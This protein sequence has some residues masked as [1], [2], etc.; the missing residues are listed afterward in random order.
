MLSQSF[1][2]LE[3]IVYD[4]AGTFEE[5]CAKFG[6]PR[7]RYHRPSEKRTTSGRFVAAASLCTGEFIGLLDDDDAY[8]PHF[9]RRI[10]ETL[11]RHP[12]AGVAFCR[13]IW[14]IDGDRHP[15]AIPARAGVQ[16]NAVA[17][18]L[19]SRWLVG[20]SIMLMRRHALEHSQALHHV[21]PDV[22]A[23]VVI[24]VRLSL[25][26]WSHVFVDEPLVVLRWHPEQ[27]SRAGLPA[28]ERTVATHR[29]LTMPTAA[30]ERVREHVLAQALILRAG[31]KLLAGHRAAAW[32]DLREAHR[33]NPSV[34]RS[35]KV[36]LMTAAALPV[37]GP[38]AVRMAYKLLGRTQPPL[39]RS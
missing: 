33:L 1:D 28:A 4:D 21:S 36:F 14:D 24:N 35:R 19:L 2:D 7:I 22:S 11:R 26:G 16:R 32:P 12:E 23:D 5:L 38:V 18:I 34:Q 10:V 8:E 9:V 25:A 31:F 29:H 13:A 6:D 27:L 20:P 30:L 15:A 39:H 37:L 3:L 17:E